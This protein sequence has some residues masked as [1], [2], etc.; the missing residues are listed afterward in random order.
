MK[1]ELAPDRRVS[2]PDV[3]TIHVVEEDAVD[4][5][6]FAALFSS[7]DCVVRIW[8]SIAGFIAT[9]ESMGSRHIQLTPAG[10]QVVSETMNRWVEDFGTLQNKFFSGSSPRTASRGEVAGAARAAALDAV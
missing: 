2:A 9:V 4:A 10:V 5:Q 8:P 6:A 7:N 1:L 3:L